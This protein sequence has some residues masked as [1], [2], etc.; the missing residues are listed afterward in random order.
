MHVSWL[1][2]SGADDTDSG[3]DGERTPS[4]PLSVRLQIQEAVEQL[5]NNS[6][7]PSDSEALASESE[8]ESCA[9]V[10]RV[11]RGPRRSMPAPAAP[12]PSSSVYDP[13]T[14]WIGP[15]ALVRP[16]ASAEYRVQSLAQC[17]NVVPCAGDTSEEPLRCL[18]YARCTRTAAG[19]ILGAV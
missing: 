17:H 13:S 18:W 7:G 12:G 10:A 2:T 1:L 6:G 11:P 8:S 15:F 14:I 4:T 16:E 19:V 3:R 9:V 5:G